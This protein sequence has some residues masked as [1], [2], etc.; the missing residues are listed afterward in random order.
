VRELEQAVRRIL[1]TGKYSGD[2]FVSDLS[3]E[4]D[5]MQKFQTGQLEAREL[6]HRYCTHLFQRFGTYEEVG[7]RT[8]LDRRT[9]K[10]YLSK[11]EK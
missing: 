5:F 11:M 3:P 10:N 9:V 4:E 1:M 6:L 8:K 7:R 2:S